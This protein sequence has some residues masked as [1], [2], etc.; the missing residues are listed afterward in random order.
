MKKL[1]ITLLCFVAMLAAAAQN[2]AEIAVGYDYT[3]PDKFGSVRTQ[4]MTLLASPAQAKFFNDISLWVDSLK[5]TPG[6]EAKYNEILRKSCMTI[7]P[8]GSIS[9]DMT[10]GPAKKVHTYVFTDPAAGALTVFDKFGDDFGQYSEPLDEMEWIVVGDSVATVM[11]Y[12]C[13]MA[14]TDYHGRQWTAWFAPEIPMPYGPWKLHGLP[15]LILKA[16]ADGGFTFTATGIELSDRL[17]S[18]MYMQENYSPVERR[19]ALGNAEY[20]TNNEESI[21]QAEGIAVKIVAYDDDGNEI[22][23][24]KYDGLRHSLEPDYK[25]R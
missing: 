16:E 7:E 17:I 22:E 12:Q 4:R 21:L 18:P 15:G 8:D 9:V 24:P 10:K 2:K 14:R 23:V 13:V 20:F 3:H 1:F 19:Q 5:S 6:G 11:D 25:S